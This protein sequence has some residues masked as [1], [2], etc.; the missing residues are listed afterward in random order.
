MS[1]LQ[2]NSFSQ[3]LHLKH[4]GSSTIIFITKLKTNLAVKQGMDRIEQIGSCS[5]EAVGE[6]YGES[7]SLE[8]LHSYIVKLQL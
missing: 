3:G 5:R 2:E 4:I 1:R 8:K 7:Y 6:G